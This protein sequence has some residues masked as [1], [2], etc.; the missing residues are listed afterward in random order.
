MTRLADKEDAIPVSCRV[1]LSCLG[2][3]SSALGC[4]LNCFESKGTLEVLEIPMLR[5]LLF[6]TY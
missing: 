2:V 1:R 3:E 4:E 6:C 5:I